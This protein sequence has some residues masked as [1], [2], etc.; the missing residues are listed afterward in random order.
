MV[1]ETLPA[2]SAVAMDTLMFP[3][4]LQ[5]AEDARVREKYGTKL[6]KSFQSVPVAEDPAGP[7]K[8]KG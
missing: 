8:N 4:L 2:T 5:S 6:R 3:N 7:V 1:L